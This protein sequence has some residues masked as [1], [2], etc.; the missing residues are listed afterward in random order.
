V[1]A[2]DPIFFLI[3]QLIFLGFFALT[4]KKTVKLRIWLK[5]RGG[6]TSIFEVK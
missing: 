6:T 3:L 4:V 5:I 2:F 1:A